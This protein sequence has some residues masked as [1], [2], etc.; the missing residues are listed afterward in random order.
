MKVAM[1]EVLV[2]GFKF[3]LDRTTRVTKRMKRL[4]AKAAWS[5]K[6]EEEFKELNEALEKAARRIARDAER[7]AGA[8]HCNDIEA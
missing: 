8:A 3:D 2:C 5:A 4:L 6:E 7:I 1:L